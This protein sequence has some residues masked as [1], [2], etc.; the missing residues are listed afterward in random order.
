MGIN[1]RRKKL[2]NPQ[3]DAR[4]SGTGKGKGQRT[5]FPLI[6]FISLLL[7]AVSIL[8]TAFLTEKLHLKKGKSMVSPAVE[9]YHDTITRFAEK[10]EIPAYVPLLEAVMMQESTGRGTDPMQASESGYNE[11]YANTPGSITDPDYSIEVGVQTLK[12][13][14]EAAECRDPGDMDRIA[15]ALQGYNFGPGYISWAVEKYG[16]YSLD[17]AQEFSQKMRAELGWN[18]YG[19]PAYVPH[20]LR[21]YEPPDK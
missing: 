20:V 5:T 18:N 19:D 1:R 2:N 15:L 13:T 7:L 10:Y 9:G 21:F 14:L 11:R 4:S 3:K 16:G 6:F 8:G 12:H 17:N